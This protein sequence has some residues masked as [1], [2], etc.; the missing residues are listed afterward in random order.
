MDSFNTNKFIEDLHVFSP[1]NEILKFSKGATALDFAYHIHSE[2]GYY[3]AA[4]KVNNKL[5]PLN[6]K[7]QSGDQV[8]VITSKNPNVELSTLNLVATHKAKS[9]I[10]K[11]L[12]NKDKKQ[13]SEGEKLWKKELEK[14]KIKISKDNF[15]NLL[16]NIGFNDEPN[17]YRDMFLNKI[18]KNMIFNSILFGAQEHIIRKNINRPKKKN[19]NTQEI[20]FTKIK[21]GTLYTL[22]LEGK[23]TDDVLNEATNI[24]TNFDELILQSVDYS[25]LEDTFIC[26]YEVQFDSEVDFS[27]IYKQ[28]TALPQIQKV[29]I[30]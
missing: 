15:L 18:D 1:K 21:I 13:I 10:L 5:V 19:E 24:I 8:E 12:R 23:M 4:V 16:Q 17:F 27:T 14:R 11:Y 3:C 22:T 28:I 2:L 9:L 29:T 26:K 25:N 20:S 30:V 7:L 6:Y